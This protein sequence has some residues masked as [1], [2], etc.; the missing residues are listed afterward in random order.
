MPT[1]QDSGISWA[2]C[3]CCCPRALQ[4]SKGHQTHSQLFPRQ[5]LLCR[6]LALELHV[7]QAPSSKDGRFCGS[8]VC[9]LKRL[10]GDRKSPRD[11]E[12]RQ[13]S[14]VEAQRRT[15]KVSRTDAASS[16]GF[17]DRAAG[18]VL[19]K[20]WLESTCERSFLSRVPPLLAS[21]IQGSRSIALQ[22]L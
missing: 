22:F 3:T 8:E 18:H 15:K 1:W 21:C 12:D 14:Q 17:R 20:T 9:K 16:K 5:S 13:S 7:A 6:G 4:Q 10:Q 11:L 19:M 2:L